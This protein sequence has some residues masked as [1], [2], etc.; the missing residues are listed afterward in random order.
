MTCYKKPSNRRSRQDT[1][2]ESYI[3]D[4]YASVQ[5]HVGTWPGFRKA[6]SYGSAS[7]SLIGY[8]T[9]DSN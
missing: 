8:E 9:T 6:Y 1:G 2:P 7:V 3:F 5:A 4:R